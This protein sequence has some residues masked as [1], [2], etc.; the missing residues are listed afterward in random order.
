MR[1]SSKNAWIACCG[2]RDR[3]VTIV[4]VTHGL[5]SIYQL[6]NRAAWIDQGRLRYVGETQR[7]VEM[8]RDSMEY[9]A[10]LATTQRLQVVK[11]ERRR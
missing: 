4:Y 1:P 7:V 2:Y 10:D 11:V 3:G 8:F 5:D 9:E 6:C